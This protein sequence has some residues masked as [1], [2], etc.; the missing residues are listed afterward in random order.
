MNQASMD[1]HSKRFIL[2]AIEE[3]EDY[4]PMLENQE[5]LNQTLLSHCM[6]GLKNQMES[7]D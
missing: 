2:A 6:A 7:Y 4:L 1:F 5:N 3:L